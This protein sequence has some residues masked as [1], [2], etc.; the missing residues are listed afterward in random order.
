MSIILISIRKNFIET[1]WDLVKGQ[2]GVVSFF[3]GVTGVV[4]VIINNRLSSSE[5]EEKWNK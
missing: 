3:S 4:K 1:I 2:L 5:V